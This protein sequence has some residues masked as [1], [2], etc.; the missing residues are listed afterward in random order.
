MGYDA[1]MKPTLELVLKRVHLDDV[2]LVQQTIDRVS[3]DGTEFDFEHRLLMPDGAIKHVHVVARPSGTE[4]GEVEFVGAVMDITERIK[5]QEAIKEIPCR[6]V[7][8]PQTMKIQ[9][10]Q[11]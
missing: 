11:L 10:W 3:R 4:S 5:S 6:V 9:L 1:T 7:G 2:D 8:I